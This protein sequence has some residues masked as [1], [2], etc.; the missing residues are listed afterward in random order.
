M[1]ENFIFNQIR[2]YNQARRQM[3]KDK[4]LLAIGV[5]VGL[6]KKSSALVP[7]LSTEDRSRVIYFMRQFCQ[8]AGVEVSI[9]E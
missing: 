3:Y 2:R 6:L 4:A 7:A 5:H 9:A 1:N 8:S